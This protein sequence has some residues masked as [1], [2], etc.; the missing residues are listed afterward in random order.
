M[1][2]GCVCF[3]PRFLLFSCLSGFVVVFD[4]ALFGSLWITVWLTFGVG[5][6]FSFRE[7][8]AICFVRA[9][10]DG[11][12]CLC[13][14]VAFLRELWKAA[15][16]GYSSFGMAVLPRWRCAMESARGEEHRE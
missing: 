8:D 4:V 13:V 15:T 11:V 16:K 2:C 1:F 12:E 7:K 14:V 5:L 6:F 10:K 3:S 9:W